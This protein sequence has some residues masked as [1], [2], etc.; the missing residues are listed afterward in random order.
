MCRS[1]SFNNYQSIDKLYCYTC[2][3]TIVFVKMDTGL[4]VI[5]TEFLLLAI[6]CNFLIRYYKAENVTKDVIC[7]VFLSWVLGLGGLLLLPY[8]ISNAVISS[9]NSSSNAINLRN[10]WNFIYWSTFTLAWVILPIQSEYHTSGHFSFALKLKDAIKKNVYALVVVG[11]IGLLYIIYQSITGSATPHKVIGFFMAMGNTY[12]VFVIICL[13]GSGLT[14]LPLR[15]Y[16]IADFEVELTRIYFSAYGVESVYQEAKFELEDTELEVSHVLNSFE[17]GLKNSKYS[18]DMIKYVSALKVSLN[19]Y[20]YVTRSASLQF[21]HHKSNSNGTSKS[22]G[23]SNLDINSIDVNSLVDLHAKLLQSQIKAHASERRWYELISQCKRSERIASGESMYSLTFNSNDWCEMHLDISNSSSNS[24]NS[25]VRRCCRNCQHAFVYMFQHVN[26]SITSKILQYCCKFLSI[27]CAIASALILWSELIIPSTLSSPFGMIIDNSNKSILIQAVSFLAIAYM[28]VCTYWSLFRINLGWTYTLQ[29]PQQSPPTSLIFNG[30]YFSRLQFALGYNFLLT[31]HKGWIEKTEFNKLMS[32]MELVPVFG[33]SFTVYVPVLIVLISIITLFNGFSK[34]LKYLGVEIE[35]DSPLCCS[36]S[37]RSSEDKEKIEIGKRLIT[38]AMRQRELKKQACTPPS[39]T[40]MT[41]SN[42]LSSGGR[43]A[44]SIDAR[45]AVSS[46]KVTGVSNQI[47]YA[48]RAVGGK[49]F[50]SINIDDDDDLDGRIDDDDYDDNNA[51]NVTRHVPS[52]LK[53]GS[54]YDKIVA[55]S[56][57]GSVSATV[58]P[59]GRVTNNWGLD[60]DE[61][62]DVYSGR[63]A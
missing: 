39:S 53:N 10:A 37:N 1:E 16:Y 57:S 44:A 58:S 22:S 35:S 11:S 31:L 55:S 28:S 3:K 34:I 54:R 60:E 52:F 46:I 29:G 24:N 21:I 40:E 12:G 32:N 13:L 48:G 43:A 19:N 61:D 30:Q 47:S 62:D 56:G 25:Y 36:S 4:S 14:G 9:P 15:L 5:L 7:T 26:Q 49:A 42:L 63:Y 23:N 17:N 2:I 18:T 59:L 6:A 41:A 38:L 51:S 20:D 33:T 8:D 45:S 50:S 27:V